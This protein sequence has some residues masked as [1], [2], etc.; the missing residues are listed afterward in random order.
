MCLTALRERDG[1]LQ[2]VFSIN[3]N[4]SSIR[5][6]DMMLQY[7][8]RMSAQQI[9]RL[10]SEIARKAM[11]NIS[12]ES[13]TQ[14]SMAII[15]ELLKF[16]K[17]YQ[18][19][20]AWRNDSY[21][22]GLCD[23]LKAF[24]YYPVLSSQ[25]WRDHISWWVVLNNGE[26]IAICNLDTDQLILDSGEQFDL[27]SEYTPA[28]E[29]IKHT[30]YKR[31]FLKVIVETRKLLTEN[32]EW[33]GR[34]AAYAHEIQSNLNYITSVRHSF[35]EWRPLLLYLNV[36]NAK[37]AKQH[38]ILELRYLGQTVAL[39][40]YNNELLLDTT[41][42]DDLNLRDFGCAISVHGARWDSPESAAFRVFFKRREAK[43]NTSGKGNQEHRLES[44][45]LT[46]FS[47]R[48]GKLLPFIQPVI[49]AML[50]FP[51]PTPLSASNHKT[52]AYSSHYGGGIDLFARVGKGR[53][54]TLA[55]LEL[56]DEN[57]A[58]EPPLDAVKQAVTYA[59]FIREL[60]RSEAGKDWWR[61][62]GFSGNIPDRLKLV[63]GCVMP[64]KG[65]QDKIFTQ[66]EL[67]IGGDLIQLHYIYFTE[68][69][70]VITDITTSLN[71]ESIQG[72]EATT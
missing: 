20:C 46:E 32:P 18:I 63:A 19:R 36:S 65:F 59:V 9:Q 29:A 5:I 64:A 1:D 30:K 16:S 70:N 45:L 40:R 47:K 6:G 13:G 27:I 37:K 53:G 72:K 54:A 33:Q 12:K 57:T 22:S 7:H 61:L 8:E 10:V 50:R 4:G 31:E 56:K 24:P 26:P 66:M 68:L 15:L 35:H 60:L 14:N 2:S 52:T 39:I 38:L 62:F 34:Y 23:E 28:I 48:T 25:N 44:L 49:V 58:T 21:G 69:K 67:K 71:P 43:R 41:S 42:Y 3:L 51:M 11:F 55:V 17:N